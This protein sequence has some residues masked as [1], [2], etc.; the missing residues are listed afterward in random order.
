MCLTFFF[1]PNKTQYETK[2]WPFL[3]FFNRE[4]DAFRK[5]LSLQAWGPDNNIVCSKDLWRRGTWLALNQKTQNFAFLT[6]LNEILELEFNPSKF[7][8]D[9][10]YLILIF[11]KKIS[12]TV[13]Q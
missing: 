11:R 1:I 4:E 10:L 5:T 12:R 7:N 3:H 2:K 13:N 9:I 8:F 6:N